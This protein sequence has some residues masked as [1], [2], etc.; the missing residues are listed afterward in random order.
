[1]ILHNIDGST[2]ESTIKTE[3]KQRTP[4]KVPDNEDDVDGD[5]DDEDE[6]LVRDAEL[7]NG[8]YRCKFCDKTLATQ[9]TLKLHI[10][11]HLKKKL[12]VCSICGHGFS[13]NSH[14]DR[15]MKTHIEKKQECQFCHTIF[16]SHQKLRAHMVALHVDVN[17]SSSTEEARTS[18]VPWTQ[19]NGNKIGQCMI[20][21][22]VFENLSQLRYHLN[23]HETTTDWISEV[24][25]PSRQ[26]YFQTINEFQ[27][28]KFSNEDMAKI[29]QAKLIVNSPEVTRMYRITNSCGWELSLT[30]S[31][32]DG[33]DTDID[34]KRMYN[35]SKCQQ[36]YDRLHKLMC[37]MKENHSSKDFQSLQCQHC[38]LCFPNDAIL[39]KHLRQQCENDQKTVHCKMCYSRFT[40]QSS[41]DNHINIYHGNE[42]KLMTMNIQPRPYKCNLCQKSFHRKDKL[43][44]HELRHLPQ[45]KR[46]SCDICQK[47]F[48]RMDYLR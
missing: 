11:L 41:L 31:E 43:K 1:M 8:R 22:A 15:H 46:F 32:T 14:L 37:H 23:W 21:D 24:D 6:Q 7:I 35:C 42:S 9:N 44:E 36:A 18:I 12:K 16:E 4:K 28:G 10:R 20:C 33:E 5:D 26:E 34:H 19:A 13:K 2:S 48:H 39:A 45:E 40:W 17:A 38:L 25:L 30:D 29:L 47:R 27:Y 3:K